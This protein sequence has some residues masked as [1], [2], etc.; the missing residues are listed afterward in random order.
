MQVTILD[1]VV[2]RDLAG[3]AVILNLTSGTYFG[4]NE[5]GTQIW[6]LLAEHGSTEKVIETILAEYE[7]DDVQFRHDLGELL[8]VLADK[9]LIELDA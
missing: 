6:H 7:V 8:H 4:L 5:I 3:E 2:F 9:G 1:D